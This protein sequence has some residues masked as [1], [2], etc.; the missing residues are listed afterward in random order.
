MKQYHFRQMIVI[1]A[2]LALIA[3]NGLA[4]ALPLNGQTTGAVSDRYPV[5]FTPA[6]YVFAIWGLIYLGLLGY[7]IYQALPA[8]ADNPRLRAIGWLFALNAAAN[9]AWLFF[10]HYELI[11]LTLPAMLIVLGTLLAIYLRLGIGVAKVGTGERWL[12][13]V[14][15]SIYV[16]WISVATIAN[17]SVLLDVSSWNG[18]GLTPAIWTMIMLAVGVVL[19]GL[20]GFL[21]GDVAYGLVV[22]WAF[23]GIAR[24]PA[25][26]QEVAL[27]AWIAA[28]VA[29]FLILLTAGLRLRSRKT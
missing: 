11:A 18:F 20:M 22:V 19:A 27:A 13:H 23:V 6:G 15:F 10:W 9:I 3:V 21:R 17:A 12:V 14:P 25:I 29:A 2:F 7:T 16:G 24:K 1:L 8:Q 28:G 5:L 26:P 4:N